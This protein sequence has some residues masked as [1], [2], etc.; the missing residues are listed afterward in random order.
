MRAALHELWGSG[1]GP[2]SRIAPQTR[3]M[4]G[5]LVFGACALCPASSGAGVVLM[6]S[7]SLLW[8]AGCRP[9][10]RAIGAVVLL[11]VA[12]LWPYFLLTPWMGQPGEARSWAAALQVPVGLAAHGLAGMLVTLGTVSVLSASDLREG[13]MRLPIPAMVSAILLQIVLQTATLSHET[14][15]IAAAMSVRGASG[16]GLAALR[17]V[18]S[19]PQVWLPRVLLRAERVA[20]AMELRGY[21]DQDRLPFRSS[22]YG[23]R[24][25]VVLLLAIAMLVTCAAV[26]YGA[27]AR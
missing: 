4:G 18:A 8:I 12:M 14:R 22:A 5:A 2:L 11:G 6:I 19:L 16:G 25:A 20:D 15:R 10:L 7:S 26:R 3:L 21:T 9:P 1:R 27:G 23:A 24:D 17:V 13:L